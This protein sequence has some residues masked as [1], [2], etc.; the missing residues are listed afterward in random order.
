M[1]DMVPI[2]TSGVRRPGYEP[3]VAR[4][5][6]GMDQSQSLRR[7]EDRVEVSSAARELGKS[8]SEIRGELVD[9]VR[10]EIERGGYDTDEKLSKALDGAID[11]VAD[12]LRRGL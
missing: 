1:T 4:V 9:R 11:S 8:R 2:N 12:D 10:G 3:G 6:G 5:P 7:G